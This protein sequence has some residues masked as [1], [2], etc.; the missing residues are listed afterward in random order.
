M[1]ME[2]YNGT[3]AV[4]R[5]ENEDVLPTW[6]PTKNF[7]NITRTEEELSI[8]CFDKNIPSN[9]KCER[10]FK[11]L[12]IVGPLDFSLIGILSKISSA[13]TEAKISLF[14]ISTYD[15]DYIMIKKWDL[16]KGIE[17]LNSVG[18]DVEKL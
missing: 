15:T 10:D 18:I 17:A 2:I 8:V 7:Y 3:Y 13:L 1:K 5:L 14:A 9:V 4:C 16:E 6:I 12:K 11:L